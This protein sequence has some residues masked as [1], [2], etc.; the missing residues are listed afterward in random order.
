MKEFTYPPARRLELTEDLF[1]HQVSDPYRWLEDGT[2]AERAGWL[3]AQAGLF[4]SDRDELP[5]RDRLAAQVRELLS[6]GY[7]GTAAWRGERGVFTR[8]GP[9]AQPGALWTRPPAG[10][11]GRGGGLLEPGA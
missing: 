2:S 1:G 4:G 11:G 7:V 6:T 5:G 9:G 10:R 8:G 3:A